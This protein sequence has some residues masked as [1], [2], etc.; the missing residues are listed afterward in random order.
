MSILTVD[1]D[2][3]NV[4]NATALADDLMAAFPGRPMCCTVEDGHLHAIA[5]TDCVH[6]NLSAPDDSDDLPGEAVA[7]AITVKALVETIANVA[8]VSPTA[9]TTTELIAS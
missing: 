7:P 5:S 8:H 2:L 9:V 1:V 4:D 3:P 6:R